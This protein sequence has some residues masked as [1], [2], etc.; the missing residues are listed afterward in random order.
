M[1][2]LHCNMYFNIQHNSASAYTQFRDRSGQFKNWLLR[3]M[4]NEV[5]Y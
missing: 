3:D 4:W 1:V 5:K 2:A